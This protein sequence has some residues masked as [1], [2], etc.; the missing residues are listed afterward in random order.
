MTILL[1]TVVLPHLPAEVMLVAIAMTFSI[2][3]GSGRSLQH[4]TGLGGA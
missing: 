4:A 3:L 1:N 2:A